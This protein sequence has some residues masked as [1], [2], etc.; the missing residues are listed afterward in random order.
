MY[1]YLVDYFGIDL[2]MDHLMVFQK[3][4]R[5]FQKT[6]F[7]FE[8]NLRQDCCFEVDRFDSLVLVKEPQNRRPASEPW[9]CV[10]GPG[11]HSKPLPGSPWASC[12]AQGLRG[13]EQKSP[14][15]SVGSYLLW[16]DQS[17]SLSSHSLL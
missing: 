8:R 5:N 16:S 17:D 9:G 3:V 10:P 11:G 4:L 13:T 15:A 2:L 1:L 12:S 6:Y 7:P 14:T